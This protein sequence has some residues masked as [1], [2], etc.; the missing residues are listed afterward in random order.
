MYQFFRPE[1]GAGLVALIE[2]DVVG[3]SIH[4]PPVKYF[5]RIDRSDP[6]NSD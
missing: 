6:P 4:E 5:R 2:E 3:K 1:C